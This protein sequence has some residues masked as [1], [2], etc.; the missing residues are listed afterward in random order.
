MNI[1]L[2]FSIYKPMNMI[3]PLLGFYEI[4]T[5]DPS[6]LQKLIGP[7]KVGPKRRRKRS[8]T[9]Y[10][11][12]RHKIPDVQVLFTSRRKAESNKLIVALM[13]ILYEFIDSVLNLIKIFSLSVLLSLQQLK[14]KSS[15]HYSNVLLQM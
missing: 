8:V 11:F 15:T 3:C 6:N 2:Q 10:Y 7:C 1:Q 4:G 12:T 14:L 5:S 9:N 13:E